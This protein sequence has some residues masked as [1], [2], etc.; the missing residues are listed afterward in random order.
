MKQKTNTRFLPKGLSILYEDRDILVVDKP[1]GLLTIATESEKSK[2]AYAALMDYVKKGSERSKNRIFIVHRLDRETSGILIFAKTETAKQTLQDSWDKTK[3]VYL[4][5]TH[6]VWKEKAGTI[7]S[8]LV[9]SKAHRVYSTDNAELGKLSKTK[10][11]VLKETPLYSLLE[12]ELLTGR[13]NQIRVHLSDK[14]H[15]IVGDTKYGN[16]T[17]SYPRM[18]L[19]SFSIQLTHPFNKESLT[20]ETQIPAYFT[21]LVGGYER[22][23]NET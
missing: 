5:V 3:K 14:K 16:D 19:H 15:P 8:Y 9:E 17:R 1:A 2:T 13:K 12:I 20:F 10:F 7:Q 23:L 18:A 21:G 4:A 11:K 22:K 6:G